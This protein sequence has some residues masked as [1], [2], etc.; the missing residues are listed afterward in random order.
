MLLQACLL[1]L[2]IVI[3]YFG[4]EFALDAA[5][6]VGRYFG[7][8][9]LVIGLLIVGFGTSL[10]ELAVSVNAARKGKSEIAVGF[11]I[12]CSLSFS[13]SPKLRSFHL[14]I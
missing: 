5:E 14:K 12:G 10:P 1:I 3:L 8:S 9:P 7:L 2:S 11:D 13:L 4:V 6:V